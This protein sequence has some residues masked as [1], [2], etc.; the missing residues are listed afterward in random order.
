MLQL[1]RGSGRLDVIVHACISD[2]G[3][4]KTRDRKF[5]A[6]LGYI[7]RPNPKKNNLYEVGIVLRDGGRSVMGEARAGSL[8]RGRNQILEEARHGGGRG[9]GRIHTAYLL[10]LKWFP[11][12]ESNYF[13]SRIGCGSRWCL[14]TVP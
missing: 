2:T 9:G 10:H 13:K 14:P 12:L 4:V 6:S 3:Q 5:Q 1:Q 7:T 8:D 11:A